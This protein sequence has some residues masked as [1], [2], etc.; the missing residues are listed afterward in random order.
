MSATSEWNADLNPVISALQRGHY[1]LYCQQIQPLHEATRTSAC[2][3]ILVRLFEEE[4]RLL[5]PGM[6]FPM[7]QEQGLM[8]LL[9]CWVVN[10]V[11]KLQDAALK[12]RPGWLAPC[13]S[14]NLSE[15]AVLDPEFVTFVASQLTK[16]KP[17]SG[18]LCFEILSTVVTEEGDALRTMIEALAPHGCSFAFGG[19]TGAAEEL[20]AIDQLPFRFVKIDGSLVRK[21][22]I[23]PAHQTRVAGINARC[24]PRGIETVA[25]FV[26][27]AETRALLIRL[28]VDYAQG[29]GIAEPVPFL[30]EF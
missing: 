25:E 20:D 2:N 3:E 9:D 27:D 23:S 12:S 4:R 13:N 28:G 1:L 30:A 17:A 18:S 6:F 24:R 29:F 22:L 11:L 10:Q 19:C 8:S 16:W 7:L 15:D 14:V 26:E 5:P 21:L